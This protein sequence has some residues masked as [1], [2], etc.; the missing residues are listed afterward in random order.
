MRTKTFRFRNEE[1]PALG[2]FVETSFLRDK[3]LF[4]AFS[5]AY[6]NGFAEE[7]HNKL[8]A[9]NAAV[10]SQVITG[11]RMLITEN[12]HAAQDAMKLMTADIKKYCK[13]ASGQLTFH[14]DSL[15]LATFRKSLRSR[16]NESSLQHARRIQQTLAP[17]LEVLAGKGFT[18]ERQA[19]WNRLIDTLHNLNLEQNELLNERKKQME[20]KAV[21]LDTFWQMT[22]DLMETGQII[23]RNTPAH[24]D[25]YTEKNLMSRVRLV[26]AP[27]KK[28]EEEV[29]PEP[30]AEAPEQTVKESPPVAA[31]AEH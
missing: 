4:A 9:V 10:D 29:V 11:R 1:L 13:M 27:K 30:V 2:V 6:A 15:N 17:D 25:E 26:I 23:F 22:R 3:D 19:E 5:P 8:L 20:D 24:R 14:L 28:P 31:L 16:N 18:E 21:L 7:Y 12:L